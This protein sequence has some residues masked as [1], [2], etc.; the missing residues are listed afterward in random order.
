VER[1]L[2]SK[3]YILQCAAVLILVVAMSPAVLCQENGA[4]GG[5]APQS[6]SSSQPV[7]GSQRQA[8]NATS[9][10]SEPRSPQ[11][12]TAPGGT[13]RQIVL[14][15]QVTDKS[16]APVRGLQQQD[17]TLLDDKQ[18]QPI[19]SFQAVDHSAL[20]PGDTP[21]EVIL[22]VDAVNA[23]YSSVSFERD[24]MKRWLLQNEG[25]LAQPTSLILFT[26]SGAK[27][28]N[29]PS[30]DGKAL[31]A[32]YDQLEVGL[33]TTTRA[34]GFYGAADRFDMSLRAIREMA[35][36]EADRPGRKLVIWISPGWPLL[37]GP[38]V[39]LTDKNEQQ[40]FQSIVAISGELRQARMTLYDID[41]LG[42]A[43]AGS[44]R[45]SYYEEFV[46]GVPSAPH[47]QAANLSLQ[48]LAVQSGGRVLNSTNDITS[49]IA[50][51]AQ[52]ANAFY[53]V[54]FTAPRA[55]RANEFHSLEMKADKPRIMV[56]TRTGYYAQP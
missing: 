20:P 36:Y 44:L 26:D 51:C 28:Q 48:V 10:Q 52:D 21:V 46:K 54:S 49:A 40:L 19:T 14:D 15:V 9:P 24:Q 35:A 18:P 8:R 12:K 41:P 7:S 13:N 50:A 31:A 53:V 47:A 39:E 23:S 27:I 30:E 22:V 34:Q 56:R 3:S 6:G 37:T 16:G 55:D 42:V 17:F 38:N 29:A 32:A 45:V 43:D 1:E 5:A 2:M 25:H 11:L 33:K 4:G